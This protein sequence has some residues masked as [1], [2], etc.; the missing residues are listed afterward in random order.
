MTDTHTMSTCGRV[1]LFGHVDKELVLVL[2]RQ[3]SHRFK[4]QHETQY[5]TVLRSYNSIQWDNKH[6]QR[7]KFERKQL[8]TDLPSTLSRPTPMKNS[9]SSAFSNRLWSRLWW[10]YWWTRKPFF[11][12]ISTNSSRSGRINA[13]WNT[14]SITCN[15]GLYQRLVKHMIHNLQ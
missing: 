2:E 6:L 9:L 15:R 14:W 11:R 3:M 10:R 7:N 12:N 1:N 4:S 8:T 5:G 13:W